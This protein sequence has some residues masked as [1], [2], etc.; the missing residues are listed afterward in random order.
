MKESPASGI[1]PNSLI[2]CG[3]NAGFLRL[4]DSTVRFCENLPNTKITPLR[5]TFND[6]FYEIERVVVYSL[7]VT[8]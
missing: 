5:V 8:L 3:H 2:Y 6:I 7:N 4:G 1:A